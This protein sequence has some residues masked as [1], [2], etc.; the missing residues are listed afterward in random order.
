MQSSTGLAARAA[1]AEPNRLPFTNHLHVALSTRPQADL[2]EGR[3]LEEVAALEA[4]LLR[5]LEHA[6]ELQAASEAAAA[7]AR[8]AEKAE[9]A[10]HGAAAGGG[11]A[12]G[13]EKGKSK[14]KAK[15]RRR[16]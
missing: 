4:G 5:A 6:G 3:S 16:G 11:E 15:A 7:A 13:E 10:A 8:A 1:P 12:G 2:A 14:K 9:A